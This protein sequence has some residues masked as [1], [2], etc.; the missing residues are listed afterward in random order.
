MSLLFRSKA[1]RHERQA[2]NLTRYRGIGADKSSL[3]NC[4][5]RSTTRPVHSSYFNLLVVNHL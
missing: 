3:V 1:K 4:Q 5:R 2:N